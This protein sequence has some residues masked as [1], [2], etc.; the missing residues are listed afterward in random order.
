[1]GRN[2]MPVVCT[3]DE[4]REKF[5][6]LGLSYADI[7]MGDI[8]MLAA[9]LDKEISRSNDSGETSVCTMRVSKKIKTKFRGDGRFAAG[10]LFMDSHYFRGRECV[11]FNPDGFI[12]F[13]G[14]ADSWNLNPIKRAFLKWCDYMVKQKEVLPVEA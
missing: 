8:W 12:G 6:A 13:A 4:A 11:S 7:S 5:R 9:L 2:K 1:M 3:N 14:W 10:Y